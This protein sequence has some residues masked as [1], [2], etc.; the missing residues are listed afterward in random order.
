M[1]SLETCVERCPLC[2]DLFLFEHGRTYCTKGC[3]RDGERWVEPHLDERVLERLRR[4]R[5]G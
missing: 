4:Q 1:T 3:P 5:N 2:E